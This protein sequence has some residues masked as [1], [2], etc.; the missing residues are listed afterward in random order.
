MPRLLD[1]MSTTEIK[2]YL[3]ALEYTRGTLGDDI[4][5][6][7]VSGLLYIAVRESL[8]EPIEVLG[9]VKALD[10]NEAKAS[11]L[12]SYLSAKKQRGKQGLGYVEKVEDSYDQRKK[13]VFLTPKAKA[14][15]HGLTEIMQGRM[16]N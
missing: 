10:I 1:G 13:Y 2:R 14:F 16:D 11:R 3:H 7:Y 6:A 9:M 5:I 12:V 8:G 15:L 4:P